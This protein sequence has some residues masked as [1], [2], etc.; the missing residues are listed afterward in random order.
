MKLGVRK[1]MV[2]SR[3]CESTRMCCMLQIFATGVT[4]ARVW[5]QLQR[6]LRH[7]KEGGAGSGGAGS[8]RTGL[9]PAPGVLPPGAFSAAAA[10][11]AG[12]R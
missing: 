9:G 5:W 4:A 11:Q 8:A 10:S 1:N 7:G 12:G 3:E 6:L 2:R